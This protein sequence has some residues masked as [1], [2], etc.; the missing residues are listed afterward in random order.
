MSGSEGAHANTSTGGF[1]LLKRATQKMMMSGPTP[2]Q[3]PAWTLEALVQAGRSGGGVAWTD[4]GAGAGAEARA[5]EPESD[6]G[7]GSDPWQ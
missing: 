5:L 6:L 4:A 3:W 1:D 7:S 2:N